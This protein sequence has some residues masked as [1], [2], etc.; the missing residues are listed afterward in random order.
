[1]ARAAARLAAMVAAVLGVAAK[2]PRRVEGAAEGWDTEEVDLAVVALAASTAA[3]VEAPVAW[4][5]A[6][7][8]AE[9]HAEGLAAARTVGHK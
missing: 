9:V 1:M 3:P 5:A 8:V 2:A 6:T 7:A 4:A